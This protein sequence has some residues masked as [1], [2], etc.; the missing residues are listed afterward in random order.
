VKVSLLCQMPLDDALEHAYRR[1]G[2]PPFNRP[3][4]GDAG[5]SPTFSV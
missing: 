3:A 1:P 2:F 5:G 4:L